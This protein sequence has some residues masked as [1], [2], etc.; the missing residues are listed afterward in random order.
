MIFMF[1][2]SL[3]CLALLLTSL[4]MS[5]VDASARSA[6]R[7]VQACPPKASNCKASSRQRL[8]PCP[9]NSRQLCLAVKGDQQSWEVVENGTTLTWRSVPDAT[10]YQVDIAGYNWHWRS[11]NFGNASF[12]YSNLPLKPGNAYLVKISAYNLQGKITTIEYVIN[13]PATVTTNSQ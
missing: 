1:N 7:F 9:N 8:V 4:M 13:T 10:H 11:E 2:R 3:F 12:N 5:T 6:R